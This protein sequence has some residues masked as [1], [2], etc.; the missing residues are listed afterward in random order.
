MFQNIKSERGMTLIEI[1]VAL[2]VLGIIVI[3]ILG[4]FRL[5]SSEI[6]TSGYR[7]DKVLDA[8]AIAD[9]LIH[10]N[11]VQKFNSASQIDLYLSGKGYHSVSAPDELKTKYDGTD[12]NYFIGTESFRADVVGYEVTIVLFIENKDYVKLWIFIIKGGGI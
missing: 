11:D 8:R 2:T 5:A 10:Q 7:T 4:M 12:V 9:D 1:I 3:G 6:Y